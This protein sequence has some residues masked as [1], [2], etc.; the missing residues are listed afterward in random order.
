MQTYTDV[1]DRKMAAVRLPIPA[2]NVL[3]VE[4]AAQP[5]AGTSPFSYTGSRLITPFAEVTFDSNGY[6]ASFFDKTAG[7][8]LTCEG[9]DPLGA[10][11]AGDDVPTGWDN[12]DI[13]LEQRYKMALQTNLLSREVVSDGGLQFRIRSRYAVG[14]QSFLTQDMVF[15]ADSPRVDFETAA[16]WRETHTLLK[17]VFEVDV[18][19]A[20]AKT[21]TQFGYLERPVYKNDTYEQAKFEVCNHKWTD[22]SET[23]Y[24]VAILNDCKY[25]ISIDGNRLA[26]TLHKSGA[27][28]TPDGDCG[29]HEFTYAFLPHTGGF[30]A[31]TVVQP[32]YE[33]NIAPPCTAGCA[34][35]FTLA[36]VDAP[37]VL[38]DTV[39]RA[40]DG[41]GYIF[42]LYECERAACRATVRFGFPVKEVAAVDMM[43][44]EQEP[45]ALDENSACLSFRGFEVR[46]LRVIPTEN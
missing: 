4:T 7:R 35:A 41:N 25:G 22:L 44:E 27:H 37:H 11:Y 1:L 8:E 12:W 19:A 24:G 28:P 2:L 32:A 38:I 29:L 31:E 14:R 21:E 5:A 3:S 18:Q 34:P 36:E 26:L 40:E 15:Y 46:T 20:Y 16:D 39:K 17:A 45:L 43:E 6:I 13:N 42:R 33:L 23:Q 30:S 9:G 10:L